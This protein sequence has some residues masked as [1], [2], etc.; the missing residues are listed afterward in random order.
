MSNAE[1]VRQ[2]EE[3]QLRLRGS[4]L[5][6]YCLRIRCGRGAFLVGTSILYII[7]GLLVPETR[8]RINPE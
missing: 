7:G 6:L 8:S 3:N 5:R 4:H 2:V 1:F